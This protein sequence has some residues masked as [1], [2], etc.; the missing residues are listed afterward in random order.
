MKGWENVTE[1][2]ILKLSYKKNIK[3]TSNTKIST[4]K[5][6]K[7][8]KYNAVKT[9]IDGI[10]FDSKAEAQYYSDSALEK[11]WCSEILCDAKRL[12]T[13]GSIH[14]RKR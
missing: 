14:Q 2:D 11:S 9:K 6:T 3:P 10:I 4:D 5:I 12:H 7:K 1:E 8:N 13:S